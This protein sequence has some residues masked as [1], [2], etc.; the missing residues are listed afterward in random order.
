M[1]FGGDGVHRGEIARRQCRCQRQD[2]EVTAVIGD[3]H[4]GRMWEI[5]RTTHRD[6]VEEP[7]IDARQPPPAPL[8]EE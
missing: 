1:I 5:L 7:Q 3:K 6:A 2:I 4:E 8:A